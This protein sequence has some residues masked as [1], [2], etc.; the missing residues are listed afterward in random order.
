MANTRKKT[1]L[2]KLQRRVKKFWK[3]NKSLIRGGGQLVLAVFLVLLL[4]VPFLRESNPG[5]TFGIDV[6]SHNG[7]IAWDDVAENGVAFAVI[8]TGGRSWKNGDLY[9]DA[10]FKRNMRGAWFHH[11][12][13]GVY[14][15]S[16]AVSE[17][18]AREEAKAVLKSVNGANLKLPVFLDVEDTGT[19]GKGRAD[20]LTRAQRTANILAFAETIRDKGY[21]PGVYANRWYLTSMIDTEALRDAGIVIWLAE[22]TKAAA[23]K[24]DG[25]YD[26]WQY[27]KTG[28]VPGIGGSVDLDRVPVSP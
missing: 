11:V 4:A 26:Y 8:R 24:Y 27:S 19:D 23:P 17:D 28:S 22:Y 18:E 3:H 12:D 7:K 5:N 13:R 14:F 21:T 20:K 1:S 2:Q 9:E 10:R 15:Y 6:S 16:Q 25:F